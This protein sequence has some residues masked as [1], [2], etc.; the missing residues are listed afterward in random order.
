M[1][2]IKKLF[3]KIMSIFKIYASIKWCKHTTLQMC[4][5]TSIFGV[6]LHFDV[7]EGP[8]VKLLGEFIG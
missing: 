4:L 2:L 8:R 7:F 1:Y 6:F 3:Y 5:F